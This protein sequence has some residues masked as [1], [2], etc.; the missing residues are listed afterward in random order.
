MGAGG[1]GVVFDSDNGNIFDL[2]GN[3]GRGWWFDKGGGIMKVGRNIWSRGESLQVQRGKYMI[4][5]LR[6][7]FACGGQT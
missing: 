3:K 6:E 5:D 1:G 7:L 4:T 2:S